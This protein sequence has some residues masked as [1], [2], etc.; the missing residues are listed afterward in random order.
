MLIN[1]ERILIKQVVDAWEIVLPIE[2][3]N[4]YELFDES[5][6]KI[7]YAYELPGLFW[8][9]WLV[10]ALL[11]Y[12]RPFTIRVVDQENN[13]LI[14]VQ[15]PFRFYF[16]CVTV[17]GDGRRRLG[18]VERRFNLIH[19]LYRVSKPD[20]SLLCELKGPFWRPWTFDIVQDGKR[21]GAVRKSWSGALKEIFTDADMFGLQFPDGAS[22]DEK[23][24]LL[25]AVF[26]IDFVH[27][28]GNPGTGH[29]PSVDI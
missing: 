19:K 28:E 18:Y 26:L 8:W 7:F 6:N 25:A 21:Y 15:R 17:Y 13:L 24:L 22:Q 20:G 2:S 27:F 16:H 11:V 3:R 14:E 29:L 4:R 9:S 23:S 1:H 12:L 5:G 10:R